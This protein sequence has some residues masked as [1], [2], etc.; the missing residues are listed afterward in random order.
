MI[1]IL[2]TFEYT[3]GIKSFLSIKNKSDKVIVSDASKK[4]Q[5]MI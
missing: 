2:P 5:F 1:I 3:K 4:I